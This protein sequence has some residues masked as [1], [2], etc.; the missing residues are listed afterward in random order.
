MAAVARICKAFGLLAACA[1]TTYPAIVGARTLRRATG[2]PGWGDAPFTKYPDPTG[3]RV[4][5]AEPHGYASFS[6][7][8]EVTA[9]KTPLD[10]CKA[11][12]TFFPTKADGQKFSAAIHQDASGGSWAQTCR[13]G[14]CDFRDPQTQP[15]GGVIGAG[16]EAY[17]DAFGAWWR[18]PQGRSCMTRDPVSWYKDCGPIL[19]EAASTY[20]DVTRYCSFTHQIFVP[21]PVGAET[22]GAVVA[23]AGGSAPFARLDGSGEQCQAVIAKQGAA[24][25]DDRSMCDSD[26]NALSGCCESVFESMKCLV[27]E[28]K[29]TGTNFHDQMALNATMDATREMR[30]LFSRYCVPLCQYSR[31]EFCEMYPHSDI[32][33]SGRDTCL[34]CVRYG[35]IWCSDTKTCECSISSTRKGC[36]RTA[37]QCAGPRFEPPPAPTAPPPPTTPLPPMDMGMGECKYLEMEKVWS[38]GGK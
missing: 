24:L 23:M 2:G 35:G 1:L 12:I 36:S 4:A 32:C 27:V 15:W 21:P 28:S 3:G 19:L 26:L 6:H 37:L 14:P 17:Q 30:E 31:P 11:C 38:Q 13:A 5:R 34:P 8:E 22:S 18:S 29:A 9:Y 7:E 33:V 25:L 20:L 16:S 10:A